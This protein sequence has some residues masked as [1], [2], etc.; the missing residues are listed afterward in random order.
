MEDNG[1]PPRLVENHVRTYFGSAYDA[2]RS[3]H[4]YNIPFSLPSDTAIR[5]YTRRADSVVQELRRLVAIRYLQCYDIHASCFSH[6]LGV[7]HLLVF[8]TTHSDPER[9]DLHYTQGTAATLDNIG[10]PYSDIL[11]L[12]YY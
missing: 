11:L 8:L 2:L 3:L 7:T 12:I 9:G 1:Y 6:S 10:H 5:D 4:Y